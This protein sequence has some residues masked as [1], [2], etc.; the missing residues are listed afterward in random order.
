MGS[1]LAFFS[2]NLA[3]RLPLAVR[4]LCMAAA[5]NWRGADSTRGGRG[6]RDEG[7]SVLLPPEVRSWVEARLWGSP[8]R[9]EPGPRWDSVT[10]SLDLPFSH[11]CFSMAVSLSL[12]SWE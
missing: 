11:P 9:P 8:S 10:A 1:S 5:R 7:V 2:G 4:K 6:L 3:Q 12:S